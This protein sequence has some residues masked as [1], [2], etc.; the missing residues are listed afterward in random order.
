VP[1]DGAAWFS[2]LPAD[3]KT[4]DTR[5]GHDTGRALSGARGWQGHAADPVARFHLGNGACVERVNWGADM[6]R[7]GRAQ[8]CGMMVN[9]LYVPDALDDNLARLGDGNP[10]ISRA[11]AKLL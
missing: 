6:S 5:Y 4:R 11:V 7:K 3:T 8:S 1:A 9:Y 10:R 2:A